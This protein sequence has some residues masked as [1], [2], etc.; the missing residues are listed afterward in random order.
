MKRL[1]DQ[2][3]QHITGCQIFTSPKCIYY[4]YFIDVGYRPT[5]CNI[6][7]LNFFLFRTFRKSITKFR[8]SPHNLATV[9]RLADIILICFKYDIKNEFNLIL[10]CARYNNLI[11]VHV[12]IKSYYWEKNLSF[13]LFLCSTLIVGL[14]INCV[15]WEKVYSIIQIWVDLF[16]I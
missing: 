7:F 5:V 12:Y 8:L 16:N 14:L 9:Y 13:N 4:K 3:Q 10:I 2:A 1:L 11:N 15:S 6:I